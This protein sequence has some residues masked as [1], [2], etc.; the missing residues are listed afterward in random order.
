MTDRIRLFEILMVIL[1]GSGKIIFIDFLEVK[2]IYIITVIVF[3]FIYFFWRVSK[4]RS[5]IKYWGLSFSNSKETFKI[6][7]IIGTIVII[8]FIIYGIYK[9]TI[10]LRWSI[11]FTLLIYPLWGLVQQFLMMSLFAGNLKD[12]K[13]G[14]IN[15]FVIIGL[16][17]FLFSIIHFPSVPL[18]IATFL[19]AIFYSIIFL[20]K[21][22]IIPLGI[23][24]GVLGGLFY[25]FVLNRDPWLELIS[26]IK[27]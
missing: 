19:M 6:I 17:S 15:N 12:L 9:N 4:N 7:G 16:T 11:L 22:N 23:F 14:N 8:S 1:T 27:K 10:Q 2:L 21:R 25:Y 5:L 26:S 20:H 13:S 24:H 18:I 3:W